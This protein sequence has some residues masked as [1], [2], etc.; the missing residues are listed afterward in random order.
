MDDPCLNV[1]SFFLFLSIGSGLHGQNMRRWCYRN[2][3]TY[4]K[5]PSSHHSPLLPPSAP[6]G[7]TQRH[8]AR[9]LSRAHPRYRGDPRASLTSSGARRGR[10][11][12]PGG[13]QGRGASRRC[14]RGGAAALC[15]GRRR[16]RAGDARQRWWFPLGSWWGVLVSNVVEGGFL[17]HSSGLT[18]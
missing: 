3:I 11:T 4:Q 12:I 9:Y 18:P 10:C 5:A 15:G 13:R 7:N 14:G 2:S 1:V 6:H 8:P 17:G 16:Q